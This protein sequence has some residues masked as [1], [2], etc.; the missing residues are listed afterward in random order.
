MQPIKYRKTK[1]VLLIKINACTGIGNG[2][3]VSLHFG[4]CFFFQFTINLQP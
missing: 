3:T 2:K 4:L 1:K